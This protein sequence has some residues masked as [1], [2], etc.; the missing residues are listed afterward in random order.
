M[1]GTTTRLAMPAAWSTWRI[2]SSSGVSDVRSPQLPDRHS[3]LLEFHPYGRRTA[4]VGAAAF[5]QPWLHAVPDGVSVPALRSGRHCRQSW[6]R[7]VGVALWHSAHAGDRA[8]V[9]DI[10]SA[11]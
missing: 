5:L 10:R 1:P 8:R 2:S 9:A 7:L 6:R 3:Q 4:Y 11:D